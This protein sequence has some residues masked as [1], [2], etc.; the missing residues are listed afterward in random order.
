MKTRVTII[1]LPDLTPVGLVNAPAVALADRQP[2]AG[3]GSRLYLALR[4]Y[5]AFA[6]PARASERQQRAADGGAASGD[7]RGAGAGD[8]RQGSDR[9]RTTSAASRSTPPALARALGMS[10][11]RIQARQDRR[12]A[13]RHRQARRPRAHPRQARSADAG[14]VPEGPHPSAGRRRRSSPACPFPIRWRRSSS[15][16]TSAGTAAA[17]R[18]A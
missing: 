12:A 2:A 11:R 13:A 8:R 9:A 16:T 17:I 7:D 15:A 3:L 18:P 10:R 14:G 4:A 6:A 5:R 1:W